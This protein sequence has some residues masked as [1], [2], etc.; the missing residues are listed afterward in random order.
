MCPFIT[1]FAWALAFS[2]GAIEVNLDSEVPQILQQA[3][4]VANTLPNDVASTRY[5]ILSA[6][7]CLQAVVRDEDEAAQTAEEA[8]KSIDEPTVFLSGT[9]NHLKLQMLRAVAEAQ[10]KR[11]DLKAAVETLR[12]VARRESIGNQNYVLI[13]F[14]SLAE[15][16]SKA[17]DFEGA[18]ASAERS[19]A[20]A[21]ALPM[22]IVEGAGRQVGPRTRPMALLMVARAFELAREQVTANHLRERAI[23][24]VD[25]IA[26]PKQREK[27]LG[28][29]IVERQRLGDLA[30][31]LA[32]LDAY[33][34][35]F[36]PGRDDIFTSFAVRC[37]KVNR[38][39]ALQLIGRINDPWR[40]I[41]ATER[42]AKTLAELGQ[43]QEA[44]TVW[45][46]LT[47]TDQ[48]NT[49]P[50]RI[51]L[52]DLAYAYARA[53]DQGATRAAVRRALA[54]AERPGPDRILQE[55]FPAHHYFSRLAAALWLV[56]DRKEAAVNM[57]KA[58]AM[59][60]SIHND[61]N[62]VAGATTSIAMAEADMENYG[63]AIET[64]HKMPLPDIPLARRIVQHG[65]MARLRAGDVA[66]ASRL[67]HAL[68]Q[69]QGGERE[70]TELAE[71]AAN[72]IAKA[73][74]TAL[75]LRWAEAQTTAERKARSLL[76]T[77]RGIIDRSSG[78]P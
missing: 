39:L 45:G 35:T 44:A 24:E 50:S 60:D 48:S 64:P 61:S 77:A 66:A 47:A 57:R 75:A 38:D 25:A 22:S 4:A 13:I 12:E 37:T 67:L 2:D 10:I 26:D 33:P 17:G 76:G 65:I 32:W 27:H 1:M 28:A 40:R 51:Y 49:A 14:T 30:G 58:R 56:G 9:R 72:R 18:V 5:R 78:P 41:A 20:A 15:S 36:G 31:A 43:W 69:L 73:G 62:V 16:Q 34:L 46:R 21:E 23:R 42:V 6:I 54:A 70:A 3:R 7:A 55:R 19:Q 8:A 52:A 11:G 74:D 71:E 68:I 59:A 63:G 29:L 53:G